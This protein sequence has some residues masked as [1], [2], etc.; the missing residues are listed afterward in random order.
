LHLEIKYYFLILGSNY[1]GMEKFEVN[2]KDHL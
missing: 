1:L 2:G